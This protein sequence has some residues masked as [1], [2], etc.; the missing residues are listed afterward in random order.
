MPITLDKQL[1]AIDV[2][3]QENIFVMDSQRAMT[4]NI[5]P[6]KI[7]VVNL[8]PKKANTEVQ[9][10][11][12]LANTPLQ[13]E[14]EFLY[15]ASHKSKNT[16][17]EYLKNYYRTFADIKGKRYDG[18]II[19][20]APVEQLPFQEVDY[21][22]ELCQLMEWSKTHVYSS[23]HLCW[24]AQAGLYYHF[25]IDKQALK[26]KL[27]GIYE[28]EVV[29]TSS[30]MRGFDD[31]YRCPHSRYTT[32]SP[33]QL[34][35][36]SLQILAEG[37]EVGV[38]IAASRDLR[39]IYSF[40]HLEYSRDTLSEEYHRDVKAGINPL[41]PVNYFPDNDP[42]KKPRLTWSL[43]ASTFFSNWINYAVYQET[44]YDLAELD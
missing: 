16:S 8:M 9:L 2:L 36:T 42:E 37:P 39:Q 32:I 43:A 14:V 11:R 12:H 40:G 25:G 10:L 6:L 18:M 35:D 44:P 34:K 20:G 31:S 1:A 41:L 5:R 17:N 3:R 15:M 28:Q 21:W 24:G 7:L 22:S 30:L 29:G 33:E 13:L 19:T 27:S 4:Q 26:N 23:L 38:A